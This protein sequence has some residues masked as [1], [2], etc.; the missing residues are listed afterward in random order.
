M[1]AEGLLMTGNTRGDGGLYI[2]EL[3]VRGWRPDPTR[4]DTWEKVMSRGS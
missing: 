4:K 1:V 2:G 3:G